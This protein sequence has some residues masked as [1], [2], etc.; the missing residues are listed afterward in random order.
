MIFKQRKNTEFVIE[1]FEPIIKRMILMTLM[2]L[3]TN[4]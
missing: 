2:N 3:I 4:K 1:F